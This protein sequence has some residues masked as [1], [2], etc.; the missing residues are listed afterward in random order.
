MTKKIA[1]AVTKGGKE[2]GGPER[3][4]TNHKSERDWPAR[5]ATPLGGRGRLEW[6]GKTPA[7]ASDQ[8]QSE[9]KGG[10]RGGGWMGRPVE[11]LSNI[12]RQVRRSWRT[13]EGMGREMEGL[14]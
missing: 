1:S 3:R 10:L 5:L 9:E 14:S 13:E 2:V 12:W 8:K 6:E 11:R 7:A 4:A